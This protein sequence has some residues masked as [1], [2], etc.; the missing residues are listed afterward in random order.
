MF[1]EGELAPGERIV[2]EQ[3]ARDMGVSRTPLI[4]AL[5]R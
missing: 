5:K 4:G 3:L 2:P 1:T